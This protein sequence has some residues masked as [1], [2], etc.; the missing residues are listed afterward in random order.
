MTATARWT[1]AAY[2]VPERGI[3]AHEIR[4]DGKH[5]FFATWGGFP[6]DAD[7][8]ESVCNVLNWLEAPLPSW[9]PE[10]AA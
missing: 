9:L 4:Y 1:W 8:C 3:V 5:A 10:R 7:T 6:D 2:G